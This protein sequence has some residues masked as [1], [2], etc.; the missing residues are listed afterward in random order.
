APTRSESDAGVTGERGLGNPDSRM[1]S[2]EASFRA[3]AERERWLAALLAHSNDL[4]AVVD[5]QARVLYANEAAERVLG[6]VPDEQLGRSLFEL[7]HPDDLE[8]VAARFLTT[9]KR[10]GA[11]KP[12][13]F[14]F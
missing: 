14:R 3:A 11:P 10:T 4:I 5:D 9:T 13:V 1:T 12:A 2:Q 8:E 7:V 6:Y